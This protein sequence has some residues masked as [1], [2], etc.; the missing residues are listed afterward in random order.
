MAT[1]FLFAWNPSQND[2]TP[3]DVGQQALWLREGYEIK[4]DWSCASSRA[5]KIHD[6]AYLIKLG[7]ELRG[8]FGSGEIVRGPYTKGL[9]DG[10]GKLIHFVDIV[11]DT[12]LDPATE[13]ILPFADLLELKPKGWSIQRSGIRIEEPV[14]DA[15]SDLWKA[16]SDSNRPVNSPDEIVTIDEVTEGARRTITINAYERNPLA[17]KKCLAHYGAQCSVCG[18]SLNQHYGV[19]H[20]SLIHVHHLRPLSTIGRKYTISPIRDL[21]PVCPN[22]HA[23]I[24][25]H[26]PPYSI[27]QVQNMLRRVKRRS[28]E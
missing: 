15:L 25:S 24:H 19:E 22:C 11:L 3:E 13:P 8:I 18:I 10:G 23:V 16:Y 17:R 7:R 4:V 21:R 14:A 5:V 26:E 27:R 1:T 2:W 12:L 28:A 9:R 6:R 20:K